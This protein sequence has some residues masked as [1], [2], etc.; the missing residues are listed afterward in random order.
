MSDFDSVLKTF[1]KARTDLGEILSSC[2]FMDAGSMDT[3]VGNLELKNP[4]TEN[5]FYLLI[6][7]SGSKSEHDEEKLSEF[8]DGVMGEG[9]VADGTVAS[10]Q[11]QIDQLWPLR[12]RIAEGLLKDGYTYK[13]DISLP[14]EVFYECV[15]IMRERLGDKVIRCV[16]Y[17][18]VGDGNLHLNLTSAD[19]DADVLALIEPFVYEWTSKQRGSISAEHGLGFKKRN[20]MHFSKGAEAIAAMKQIKSL[21]DPNGIMNP[22]KVLPEN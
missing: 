20:F 13:Y 2:E 4:I 18:H 8:L 7:T 17:G 6:E 16:G 22:Y 14:L 21:F 3:V 15:N 11:T 10:S 12:E 5:Q 1:R 9:L 19:Y